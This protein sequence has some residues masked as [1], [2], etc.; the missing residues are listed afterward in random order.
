MAAVEMEQSLL[1]DHQGIAGLRP[2][3]E[4]NP[5]RVRSEFQLSDFKADS[6]V[7]SRATLAQSTKRKALC[8]RGRG[9]EV[10]LAFCLQ[11]HR[12]T[13]SRC[14]RCVYVCSALLKACESFKEKVFFCCGISA[15]SK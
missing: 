5:K 6:C 14:Q 9:S 4:R 10:R 11:F 2:A 13:A 7:T 1:C 12:K 15:A 3:A 8:K